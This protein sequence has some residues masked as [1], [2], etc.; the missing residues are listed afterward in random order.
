MSTPN[1]SNQQKNDLE[2]LYKFRIHDDFTEDMRQYAALEILSKN[3]LLSAAMGAAKCQLKRDEANAGI[4][5]PNWK[6]SE[7]LERAQRVALAKARK[8]FKKGGIAPDF[9]YLDA[10]PLEDEEKLSLH[11]TLA[12]PQPTEI[13]LWR[14]ANLDEVMEQTLI[15][16]SSG[17]AGVAKILGVGK[18]RGQQKNV[19]LIKKM[20]SEEVVLCGGKGQ[21]GLNFGGA[22]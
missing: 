6:K 2:K 7:K 21:F 18:R 3:K 10:E 15:L 14:L 12:A 16:M 8:D 20:V 13:A 4:T 22:I 5:P 11:E 19:E 1:L 9:E 17:G